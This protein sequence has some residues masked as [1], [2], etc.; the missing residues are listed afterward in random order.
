MTTP[1]ERGIARGEWILKVLPDLSVER[2]QRFQSQCEAVLSELRNSQNK[3]CAE[4]IT[5]ERDFWT[6]EIK[7][8]KTEQ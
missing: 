2:L 5:A 1:Q 6:N 4:E 7:K 8:R 3:A